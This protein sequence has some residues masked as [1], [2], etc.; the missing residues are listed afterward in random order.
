ME[1]NRPVQFGVGQLMQ[2][3]TVA[4]LWCGAVMVRGNLVLGLAFAVVV[5]LV[6]WFIVGRWAVRLR[7]VACRRVLAGTTTLL[8][9]GG[10]GVSI[11]VQDDKHFPLVWM[12]TGLLAMLPWIL[13]EIHAAFGVV[14]GI[15]G[16]LLLLVV[17][18]YF[19]LGVFGAWDRLSARSDQGRLAGTFGVLIVLLA[20]PLFISITGG[21]YAFREHGDINEIHHLWL[22]C[23]IHVGM[24]VAGAALVTILVRHALQFTVPPSN[25]LKLLTWG[26]LSLYAVL[27]QVA[28][29]PIHFYIP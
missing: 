27:L 7:P 11:L 1:A 24:F 18:Y 20:L 4:A 19:W 13:M 14:T 23:V 6:T 10:L 16:N 9:G 25:W 26:Y 12:L 2:F 22:H 5:F 3:I 15:A 8:V 29:F 28:L 17:I 21:C